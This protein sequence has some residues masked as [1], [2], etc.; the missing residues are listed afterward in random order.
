MLAHLIT[1]QTE[2][3]SVNIIVGEQHFTTLYAIG[4]GTLHL[5]GYALYQDNNN[6][7]LKALQEEQADHNDIF[8]ALKHK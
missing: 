2:S 6:Y 1:N 4:K 3:V 5:T 7:L 8:K